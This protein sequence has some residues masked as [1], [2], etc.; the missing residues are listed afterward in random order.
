MESG[1][2]LK[3]KSQNNAHC[4]LRLERNL[5]QEVRS[6]R[7]NSQRKISLG[8]YY[9]AELLGFALNT[10]YNTFGRCSKTMLLYN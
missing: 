3:V 2:K 1:G 4:C 6:I 5:L 7:Q 9:G 10:K 8:R